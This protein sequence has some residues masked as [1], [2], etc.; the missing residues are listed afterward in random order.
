M[1]NKTQEVELRVLLDKNTHMDIEN[2]LTKIGAV[3][4]NMH[5]VI[6]EYFCPKETKFFDEVKMQKVGSYGL[7]LRQK[8][9]E[10]ELNIKVITT[11]DDHHAWEEHEI[12]IDSFVEAKK[13]LEFLGLKSFIHIEKERRNF[14]YKDMTVILEDIKDFGLALEIEIITQKEKSKEAKEKIKKFLAKLG[15]G[16]DKI[17]PKSVTHIIMEQRARF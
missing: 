15:I 9:K 16:E 1:H 10:S 5:K 11:F 17:V 8:E 4:E 13:I 14:T 7:R 6:D 2:K 12:K 3:L